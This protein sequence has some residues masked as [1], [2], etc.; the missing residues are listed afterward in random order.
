MTPEQKTSK[1][2]PLN[3][4]VISN[5]TYESLATLRAEPSP[6][7]EGIFPSIN[8]KRTIS[9]DMIKEF[10]DKIQ[11]EREEEKENEDDGQNPYNEFQEQSF[12]KE[13]INA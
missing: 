11:N 1:V 4:Y 6:A 12:A 5:P 8:Y 9:M 7:A 2:V 3:K 10:E 13:P